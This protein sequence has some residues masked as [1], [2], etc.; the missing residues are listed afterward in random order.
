[1]KSKIDYSKIIQ[2]YADI[3][4]QYDKLG[5]NL[6]Q[7]LEL[8]LKENSISYLSINYR[9]KESESF[10]GKIE[11][12]SYKN[13]LND[14]EDIC[15][16]R[17]VCYYQSDVEKIKEIIRKEFDIVEDENKEDNLEFDQF[18]YR[19]M[20]YIIK[21]KTDWLNTP[22]YRGLE[23]LKAE[24]QIRTVLM[25]AWAEIEHKL[26]YKSKLQIPVEFRRKLSRISAKLEESD[27]QFEDIKN[28][29]ENTRNILIESANESQA[30]DRETEFN[31]D[32]LQA[33][34]DY[35]FPERQ[36]DIKATGTLFEEMIKANISLKV[37]VDGFEKSKH[38][39]RD[40]EKEGAQIFFQED[41][42]EDELYLLQVGAARTI[43]E[44]V[45]DEYFQRR[46]HLQYDD[47]IP[48]YREI[49]KNGA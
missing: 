36:K 14:I 10:V 26:A 23:N 48:K 38:L 18:G 39:L 5:L 15:G 17:I 8:L 6:S 34:L 45:D 31:L 13:P 4:S 30:F 46:E 25:H 20:H 40:V 11:R 24:L 21:I 33:F 16:V 22:N 28:Q 43:L 9:I 41:Y 47:V 49:L 27:E 44:L 29:I 7:A 3:S 35:A 42:N 19:S 37:L 12:K 2:S 32:T 1:M